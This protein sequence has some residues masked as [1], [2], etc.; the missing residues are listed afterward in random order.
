[1]FPAKVIRIILVFCEAT[2]I[3]GLWE[4]HKN[5][6]GEDY[7]RENTNT[8]AVEQHVLRDI[9][10]MVHSMGKDFRTYCLLDVN[11]ASN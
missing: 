7:S 2:D 11:D 9:R 3:R 8:A 1:M 5:A 10:D 4:K 6:M